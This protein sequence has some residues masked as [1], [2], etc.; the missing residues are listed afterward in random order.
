MPSRYFGFHLPS[1]LANPT[2][3]KGFWELWFQS[4]SSPSPCAKSANQPACK[5][6]T[7]QPSRSAFQLRQRF[8]ERGAACS[9]CCNAG[10][11]CRE[12]KTSSNWFAGFLFET[13]PRPPR[14]LSATARPA[15]TVKRREGGCTWSPS[16]WAFGGGGG[17]EKKR[18]PHSTGALSRLH[19]SRLN[20]PLLHPH[21]GRRLSSSPRWLSAG[22]GQSSA[23]APHARIRSEI[24][25][26]PKDG[27]QSS[28]QGGRDG[29]AVL[30]PAF[31][32]PAGQIRSTEH[33]PW[34]S[35]A[36]CPPSPLPSPP[37]SP[38]L[39]SWRPHLAWLLREGLG[40][41]PL[42]LPRVLGLRGQLKAASDGS[43]QQRRRRQRRRL[44][45]AV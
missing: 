37:G 32:F 41:T 43:R 19:K 44:S 16:R 38:S 20:S 36:A 27:L 45:H 5:V 31:P 40:K 18:A 3:D 33:P 7:S 17:W 42:H 12:K 11:F 39:P 21:P 10:R 26:K 22:L 34:R 24:L 25:G 35:T 13:R 14:L 6:P 9:T 1:A 4:P 15:I 29:D 30:R 28:R 8:A 23:A 2:S